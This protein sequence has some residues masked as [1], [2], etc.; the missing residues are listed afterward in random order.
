MVARSTSWRSEEVWRNVLR[1]VSRG[2]EE[3]VGKVG[4]GRRGRRGVETYLGRN[5]YE[6]AEGKTWQRR[7][8]SISDRSDKCHLRSKVWVCYVM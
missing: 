6:G 7:M 1:G 5:L 8:G 3:G 4:E 2:V